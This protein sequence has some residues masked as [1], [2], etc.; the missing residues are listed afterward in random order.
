MNNRYVCCD[1]HLCYKS[2]IAITLYNL[3]HIFGH[4][5]ICVLEKRSRIK[6]C[7]EG[8]LLCKSWSHPI[9]DP[10]WKILFY[11]IWFLEVIINLSE[12]QNEILRKIKDL[13]FIW[14]IIR[15]RV[16]IWNLNCGTPISRSWTHF[17]Y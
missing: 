9:I 6:I 16:Q 2:W 15:R 8:E 7:K 13:W 4:Q 14:M 17:S 3:K 12:E 1:A 10:F 5:F 11:S